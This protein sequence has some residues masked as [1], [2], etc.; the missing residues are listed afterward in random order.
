MSAT[1][2]FYLRVGSVVHQSLFEI[3]TIKGKAVRGGMLETCTY[4]CGFRISP[5]TP[6]PPARRNH[7]QKIINIIKSID[8]LPNL[9]TECLIYV[10]IYVLNAIVNLGYQI[11]VIGSDN[12]L[13]KRWST[14][15]WQGR[16]ILWWNGGCNLTC[17]STARIS[18]H[19]HQVWWYTSYWAQH[20]FFIYLD[21]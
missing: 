15:T 5:P 16:W 8:G 10:L 17:G 9:C 20:Q 14:V 6:P 12:G 11:E 4:A 1:L 19:K 21:L 7:L 3:K 2:G 13:V 18:S